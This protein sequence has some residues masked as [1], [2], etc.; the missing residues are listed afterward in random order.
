[1]TTQFNPLNATTTTNV[2]QMLNDWGNYLSV[3][4][5]LSPKTVS[6]YMEDMKGFFDFLFQTFQ[7]PVNEKILKDLTITDFRAFLSWRSQKNI[8]RNSVARGVSALKNFFK[9]LMRQDILKNSVVM[10]VRVARPH[11]HL[12]HPITPDQAKEFLDWAFKINKKEWSGWRDKAL[13]TLMYGCGL[14]IA[15]T[16]SLDV[17]DVSPVPEILRIKGK[18][19]KERLVP[20]LPAV[21]RTLQTYLHHHPHPLMEY[22][23]FVGAQGDRINP[24]VVQRTV[25]QIR[26]LMGLPETV[27]PHALRHSFATHL[28]QNGGDLRSIQELLGHSSLAATQRYTEITAK[29]MERTYQKA[30]PRALK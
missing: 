10:S 4:R 1:M 25:R 8:D 27:T 14:R 29:D 2:Q 28:L 20:V 7:E 18:G 21:R 22:P 26:G 11:H 3:Q 19:N 5:R 30:H 12:P 6:S 9:Y 23:L 16:L 13:F 17:K 15:E 24:G